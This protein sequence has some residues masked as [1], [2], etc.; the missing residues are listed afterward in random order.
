[1]PL[2]LLA[3]FAETCKCLFEPDVAAPAY[4]AQLAS[5]IIEISKNLPAIVD[6]LHSDPDYI[7]YA[8]P[9][10]NIDNAYWWRDESG[11]L[12]CGLI[13]FGGYGCATVTQLLQSSLFSA[14]IWV[15]EQVRP[16]RERAHVRPTRDTCAPHVTRDTCI[17]RESAHTC[18]G[19][20]P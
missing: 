8:H 13:D 14:D 16:P 11:Q 12:H 1:M 5:E 20:L 4:Q 7:G 19:T 3:K 17:H 18:N 10:A 15:H 6:Y 2:P 9:N